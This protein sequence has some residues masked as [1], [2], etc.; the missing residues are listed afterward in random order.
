LG[1]GESGGDA[2]YGRKSEHLLE[3]VRRE[4]SSV[5][6]CKV[7]IKACTYESDHDLERRKQIGSV[8]VRN[9][10][11]G[12]KWTDS[13]EIAGKSGVDDDEDVSVRELLEAEEDAGWEDE[14]EHLEVEEERRPRRWLMLRDRCDNRD[15]V[16]KNKY[17]VS[18]GCE[19]C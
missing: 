17:K 13:S 18:Q 8:G 6:R 9:E 15:F 5:I 10:H 12:R 2:D 1:D 11:K 16:E 14:D 19:V 3:Q 7:K 4:N